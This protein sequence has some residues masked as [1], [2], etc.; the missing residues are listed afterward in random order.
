MEAERNNKEDKIIRETFKE[1]GLDKAPSTL[2]SAVMSEINTSK[3]IQYQPLIKKGWWFV[4]A[5]IVL[6]IL[7]GVFYSS[8]QLQLEFLNNF[9]F[10][11]PELPKWDYLGTISISGKIAYGLILAA[12]MLF[13]QFFV[14]KNYFNKK[15]S[16]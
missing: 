13:T 9:K 12:L 16:L 10:S 8:P 2:L 4:I 5:G 7:I 15:L 1:I 14:L 11:I 3:S 6:S